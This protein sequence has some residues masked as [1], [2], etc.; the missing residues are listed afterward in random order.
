MTTD[1]HDEYG[2][3][4]RRALSAEAETVDPSADGLERIRARIDE[5]R[6]RR[7]GWEWFT[8][9]WGRPVL[10][11]GAAVAIAGI[12]VSAPQTMDL[13]QS[14]GNHGESRRNE[15]P[16]AGGTLSE[17]N[18][19]TA[20]PQDPRSA[21]RPTGEASD[22]PDAPVSVSASGTVSCPPASTPGNT[23]TPP[24]PTSPKPPSGTACPTPSTTAPTPTA[25]PTTPAPTTPAPTTTTP[26]PPTET[27][28]TPAAEPQVPASGP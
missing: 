18:G 15:Q 27:P 19:P 10:A 14:A 16:P 9:N 11:V 12:G 4:L 13:I 28:T 26:A 5:R 21:D 2:E 7:F 17:R 3:I 25:T 22:D 6:R 8:A 24:P 1:P 23:R 20:D